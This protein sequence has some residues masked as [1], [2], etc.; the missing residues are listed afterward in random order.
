MLL[1]FYMLPDQFVE[2][3][4]GRTGNFSFVLVVV[5]SILV[6]FMPTAGSILVLVG[7]GVFCASF[8]SDFED[9]L[10]RRRGF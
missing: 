4:T 7:F 8:A 5:G 6:Y 3:L 9:N 2:R 10:S 1:L